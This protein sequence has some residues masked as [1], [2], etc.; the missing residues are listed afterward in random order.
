[1]RAVLLGIALQDVI[2]TNIDHIPSH[3]HPRFAAST[4]FF[5]NSISGRMA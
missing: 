5:V 2:W 1:M 4:I 3:W